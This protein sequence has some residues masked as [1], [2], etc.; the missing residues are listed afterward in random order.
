[1]ST[2]FAHT[3]VLLAGL[4]L[5]ADTALAQGRRYP[6]GQGGQGQGRQAQGG[7]GQGRSAEPR[8]GAREERGSGGRRADGGNRPGRA[9]D[10]S[11]RR[12]PPRPAIDRADGQPRA[13]VQRRTA[14]QPGIGYQPPLEGRSLSDN[15][16]GWDGHYGDTNRRAV[17]RPALGRYQR[18]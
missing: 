12:T 14:A 18:G 11:G 6:G 10:G 16:S 1:M 17:P 15:R 3:A 13:E 5:A 8:G 7:Q 4:A 9:D 2:R